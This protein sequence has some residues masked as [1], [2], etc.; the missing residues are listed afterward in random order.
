MIETHPFEK[1]PR[2]C[3]DDEREGGVPGGSDYVMICVH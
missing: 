3:A 2:L 1:A